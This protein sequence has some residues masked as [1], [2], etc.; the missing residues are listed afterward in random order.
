[1]P[2]SVSGLRTELWMATADWAKPSVA[3]TLYRRFGSQGLPLLQFFRSLSREE[4][5]TNDTH[6]AYEENWIHENVTVGTTQGDPGVGNALTIPLH[7]SD[8][9]TLNQFYAR[10]DFIITMPNETQCIIQSIDDSVSASPTI[11]IKPL[12]ASKTIG[13]TTAGQKL[14]ITNGVWGAGEDQPTGA[15]TGRTK[16]NFYAQIFKE[17][18]GMEGSQLVNAEWFDHYDESTGKMTGVYTPETME[19]EFRLSIIEDGAYLFGEE[20]TNSIVV[21]PGVP[22]AGNL[23]RT[24]KGIIPWINDLGY[25][26]PYYPGSLAITDL[27]NIGLYLKSQGLSTDVV[28]LGVGARL[29]NEI[30]NAA[31]TFEGDANSYTRVVNNVFKGNDE[32]ALSV[33]YKVITKGGITFM[34]NE[35]GNFSNPKTFGTPLYEF[36]KYG[37]CIP[38]SNVKDAQ[39][40]LVAPNISSFYR[41]KG[42]YN[43]RYE[44][45]TLGGAGGGQ[46]TTSIDKTNT[47]WRTHHG[48]KFV[49]ANQSVLFD[50]I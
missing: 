8:L 27:D 47:F 12:N 32:L 17:T 4:A 25:T 16:R 50:P 38:L 7:S 40:G 46:Y 29:M 20:N 26:F 11:T 19:G 42:A 34:L 48:L 36:D 10:Q 39:S 3:N 43:R 9:N 28:W 31:V 1:M 14:A 33:S 13:A 5:I 35:I 44:V 22:G 21:N 30:N 45:F 23:K 24:T 41:A 18:I 2:D 6:S 49:K 15:V 37:I